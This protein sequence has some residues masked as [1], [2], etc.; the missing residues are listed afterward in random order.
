VH[1]VA[2][3]AGLR[4]L[5]EYGVPFQ[6]NCPGRTVSLTHREYTHPI[7]SNPAGRRAY[8]EELSPL[9]ICCGHAGRYAA[10]NRVVTRVFTANNIQAYDL[11]YTY[12]LQH[13]ALL[14]RTA[15]T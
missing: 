8:L 5:Q 6:P 12:A 10:A 11:A 3:A 15:Y 1:R 2:S 4:L 14:P 13:T 7:R 9:A